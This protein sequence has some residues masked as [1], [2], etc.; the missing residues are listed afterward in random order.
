MNARSKLARLVSRTIAVLAV[1]WCAD[2]PAEATPASGV[3]FTVLNSA[4]VPEFDA[5]RR[6]RQDGEH[7]HHRRRRTWKIEMEA[8]RMIDVVTVLFTV[9]R[10]DGAAGTRIPGPRSSPSARAFSP[11]TTE[12]TAP[13]SRKSSPPEPGRSRRIRVN[14]FTC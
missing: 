7:K 2:R 14:T 8:T 13:A 3:T 10:V 6:Y 1:V 4:T 5:R 9:Q 11:C 12:T